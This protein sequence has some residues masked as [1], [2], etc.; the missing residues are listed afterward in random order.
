MRHWKWSLSLRDLEVIGMAP[1]LVFTAV[2][3]A[4]PKDRIEVAEGY[5]Q[6]ALGKSM[7][8]GGISN[9]N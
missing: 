2:T 5:K 1:G 7:R 6:D 3:L 9:G 8:I 4:P